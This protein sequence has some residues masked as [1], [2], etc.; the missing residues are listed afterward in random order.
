MQKYKIGIGN[1]KGGRDGIAYLRKAARYELVTTL[2][3]QNRFNNP[4][5]PKKADH[6]RIGPH[7]GIVV[8]P[9]YEFLNTIAGGLD[10]ISI[11]A[12]FL[13]HPIV[14]HEAVS[15]KV[16]V[17]IGAVCAPCEMSERSQDQQCPCHDTS[18]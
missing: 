2:S 11:A 8:T 18:T 10:E 14:T 12:R 5:F 6:L 3:R 4:L 1:G 9:S 15:V 17:W 13:A 16:E 7:R